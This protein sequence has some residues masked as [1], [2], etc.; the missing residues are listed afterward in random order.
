M[1]RKLFAKTKYT[2]ALGGIKFNQKLFRIHSINIGMNTSMICMRG[3]MSAFILMLFFNDLQHVMLQYAW[4]S[5]EAS[6]II[7]NDKPDTL[8]WNTQT[9]WNQIQINFNQK[10]NKKSWFEHWNN[11]SENMK[12]LRLAKNTIIKLEIMTGLFVMC[13]FCFF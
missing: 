1:R 6:F 9:R 5:N 8:N 13:W 4:D 10:R 2:H 7:P 11:P 12:P 3:T